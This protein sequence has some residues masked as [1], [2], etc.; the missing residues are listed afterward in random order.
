MTGN[1]TATTPYFH[2]RSIDDSP[3]LMEQSYKLR[4]QV[5]CCERNFLPIENYPDGR[6][7]DEFDQHSVHVGVMDAWGELAATARVVSL[8]KAGPGLPLFQ[9]C[10]IFAD[11][12]ELLTRLSD[13]TLRYPRR[14]P[15]AFF[16][17]VK[18]VNEDES[19]ADRG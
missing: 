10:R 19:W 3:T 11:E 17:Y 14:H 18:R 1:D 13:E 15:R 4:Y 8:T 16:W 9:H 5:Y 12:T 6:E 2:T 7:S